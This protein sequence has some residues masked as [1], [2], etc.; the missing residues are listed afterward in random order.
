MSYKTIHDLYQDGLN[1]FKDS[2]LL[3]HA[4]LA[5]EGQPNYLQVTPPRGLFSWL[6]G[7]I[8]GQKISFKKARMTRMKL[9][10]KVGNI[11]FQLEDLQKL[12]SD[13]WDSLGIENFQ[14]EIIQKVIQATQKKKLSLILN[15]VD[16][17]IKIKGIGEWTLN[18]IKIMY[19]ATSLKQLP[20][21]LL[22][23][24]LVVK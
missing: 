13:D 17:W 1:F 19:S 22:T 7:G 11:N 12:T 8:I 9:Y 6:I 24:D 14:L 3:I 5:K 18:N 20:D 23:N 21:I 4:L 10:N 15:D 2:D 16:D